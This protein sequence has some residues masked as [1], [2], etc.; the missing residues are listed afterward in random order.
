MKFVQW[1]QFLAQNRVMRKNFLF[2]DFVNGIF[3]KNIQLNT[4][5]LTLAFNILDR[6]NVHFV[7]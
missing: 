6:F 7:V 1:N 4:F 5:N 2:C 3:T